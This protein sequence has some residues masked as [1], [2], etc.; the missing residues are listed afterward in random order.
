VCIG[1]KVAAVENCTKMKNNSI[2][3]SGGNE[4]ENRR[5]KTYKKDIK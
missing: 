1:H 2:T 3:K 5:K 4:L